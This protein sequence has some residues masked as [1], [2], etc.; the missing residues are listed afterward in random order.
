MRRER[1]GWIPEMDGF[2]VLMILV[3]AWFHLWQQSWL[4]PHLG[5]YS[6][7]YLVRSGYM[8]VDGT[9]LLSGFLLF[10]PYA[11]AHAE[12]EGLPDTLSFYKRRYRRIVPSYLL[13]VLL[14]L[15]VIVLPYRLYSSRREL[16]YDLFMHV[17]MIFNWD[18]R[19]Y[20]GTQLGG[21][22]WTIAVEMQMYALFPF[23]A[24]LAVR[25]PGAVFFGMAALAAYFRGTCLFV[26]QDYSMVVNQLPS[27]LD[28]YALG[29]ALALA[30][31][32]L[33]KRIREKGA[34]KGMPWAATGL[35]ILGFFLA[36]LL[37]RAQAVSPDYPAI[38]SGQM[39][40]RP[41]WGLILGM[42]LIALPFSIRPVRFLFGNPVMRFLSG[43]SMN[44]YL[45][46]QSVAVHL[47]RLGIPHSAYDLPNQ[48]G[49]SAWQIRYTWL[50]IGI[51]L[52]LAA[53]MTYLV[54]KP[55]S[56]L[57]EKGFRAWD[58]RRK[59]GKGNLS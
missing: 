46:H 30:Y 6:L 15:F 39:I 45:L 54:E 58:T 35:I 26:M 56:R 13:T 4:T 21:A 17:L 3:V 31:V 1:D 38:Q 32:R 12:Q 53:L 37:L 2:R 57:L 29:M 48:A 52:A 23:L 28:I 34:W 5:G 44:F 33:R 40:R 7:D 42:I 22:A 19:T 11:R 8:W 47:K 24:R 9:I 55:C 18:S 16:G 43:I 14:H 36:V 27:F 51:S 10:L 25:K 41:L 49:D 20:L 50:S 59:P